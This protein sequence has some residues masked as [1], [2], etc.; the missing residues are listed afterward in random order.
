MDGYNFIRYSKH[1]FNII[2]KQMT[3]DKETP[4]PK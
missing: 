3:E 1:I 4:E 2:Q